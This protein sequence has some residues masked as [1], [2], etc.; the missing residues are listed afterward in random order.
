MSSL[1]RRLNRRG[2]Q[3]TVSGVIEERELGGCNH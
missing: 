1:S 2:V 3:L